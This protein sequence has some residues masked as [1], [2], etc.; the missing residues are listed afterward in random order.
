MRTLKFIILL[1]IVASCDFSEESSSS[2]SYLKCYNQYREL[3]EFNE[4]GNID[5]KKAFDKNTLEGYELC[6]DM[7]VTDV[8]VE[9]E[10]DVDFVS[11]IKIVGNENIPRGE[12][13][14]IIEVV[15]ED[16]S[17]KSKYI[18]KVRRYNMNTNPIKISSSL[19]FNHNQSKIYMGTMQETVLEFFNKISP[20][21]SGRYNANY[22]LV[23]INNK[24][25][26][27]DG[28]IDP[29][30]VWLLVTADDGRTTKKYEFV[31]EAIDSLYLDIINHNLVFNEDSL[32]NYGKASIVDKVISNL[33]L[34]HGRVL[35][36][37]DWQK[38]LWYESIRNCFKTNEIFYKRIL[39][40]KQFGD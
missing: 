35:V 10:A 33:N 19:N 28:I 27:Y 18:I 31:Y 6:I 1:L 21:D 26:D 4:I 11:Q 37:N 22:K 13:D 30:S 36:L 14:L 2:L 34:N 3:I 38:E 32:T 16:K 5:Q 29:D 25:I 9:C 15:S 23:D 7:E 24:E 8:V 17:S 40:G 39:K 20:P 12:S